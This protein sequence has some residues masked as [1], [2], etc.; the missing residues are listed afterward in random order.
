MGSRFISVKVCT[1][2][3][4]THHGNPASQKAGTP[5]YKSK[6]AQA[7]NPEAQNF[8]HAKAYKAFTKEGTAGPLDGIKERGIVVSSTQDRVPCGVERGQAAD[9]EAPQFVVPE[10]LLRGSK[11]DSREIQRREQCQQQAG[12]HASG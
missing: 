11:K 2:E 7:Q 10:C 4:R 12:G 6:Q 1:R 3:N 5:A 8:G 9:I